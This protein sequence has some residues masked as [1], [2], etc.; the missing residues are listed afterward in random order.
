[1]V[2]IEKAFREGYST[3]LIV[4]GKSG[5]FGMKLRKDSPESNSML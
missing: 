5:Q 1:M 4:G 3:M 2:F